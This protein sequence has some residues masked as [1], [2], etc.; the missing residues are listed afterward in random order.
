M[1]SVLQPNMQL[2]NTRITVRERSLPE[3]LDLALHVIREYF[4]PWLLTTLWVIV[5]LAL[6]NYG[7]IG[8]MA[9]PSY[10][11]Y[12]DG[13][14]PLRFLWNLTLLVYLESPLVSAVSVAYLGPAVF[15]EQ[16]SIRQVLADS[17]RRAP[18]LVI[19]QLLIRG[20]LPAWLLLLI[21]NVNYRYE[22]NVGIEGVLLPLL[23]L[24]ASIFRMVRPYISEIILLERLPW[25]SA[26]PAEMTLGKRSSSL[27]SPYAG[28]LF[29]RFVLVCMLGVLLWVALCASTWIVLMFLLEAGDLT[30]VDIV[31]RLTEG[32]LE[33]RPYHAQ[34][35]Y[36]AILWLIAAYFSV[37]RFLDYLDLRI[38][39]EGWEVELLMRAEALR[40]AGKAW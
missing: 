19:S 30:F 8:W 10:V 21:V 29:V 15:L 11:G 33:F 40:L 1:N 14:V 20:I 35:A 28:D 38:R 18:Q 36:P 27:H 3:I 13:E 6:L 2:D 32:Q 17:L 34:L 4:Q 12:V 37:V 25:R 5:P 24:Y 31:R 7:L 23:A 9:A 26:N 39:H 22:F 16:R